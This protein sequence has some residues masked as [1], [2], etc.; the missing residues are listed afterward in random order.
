MGIKKIIVGLT[1]SLLFGNGVVVASDKNLKTCLTG[2][3]PSLCKLHL[4]TAQQKIQVD[5]AVRADNLKTCLTGRYSSLCKDH[6]LTAQQRIQVGNAAQAASKL[7]IHKEGVAVS[8]GGVS[9][10]MSMGGGDQMNLT[11]GEYI[12]SMGGGDQ[13]NLTTGDYIM[14]MGGGDKMNLS[15]GEYLMDMGGGDMMNLSTGEFTISLD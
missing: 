3:Y 9:S 5:H 7:K 1:L 10:S 12:M 8:Y 4:L 6:L 2:R 11:T 15:T 13:M 14:N